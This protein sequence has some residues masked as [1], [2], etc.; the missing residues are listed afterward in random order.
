MQKPIFLAKKF[1]PPSLFYQQEAPAPWAQPWFYYGEEGNGTQDSSRPILLS[2]GWGGGVPSFS[3]Q[4]LTLEGAPPQPSL[5]GGL[6]RGI[7]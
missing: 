4:N 3:S 6:S 5:S 7:G 1:L 2:W